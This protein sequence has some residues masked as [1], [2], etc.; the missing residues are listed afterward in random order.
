MA[1]DQILKLIGQGI[2]VVGAVVREKP[3]GPIL[4]Q[5]EIK[6][7]DKQGRLVWDKI[8]WNE[9]TFEDTEGHKT[10]LFNSVSKEET[11]KEWKRLIDQFGK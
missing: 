7:G 1:A 9:I 10:S 6:T 11:E 2:E 5:E 8:I 4:R 3:Y